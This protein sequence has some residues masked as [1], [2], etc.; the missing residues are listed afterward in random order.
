MLSDDFLWH[1]ATQC[2]IGGDIHIIKFS[3][4]IEAEVRK[5]DEALIRQL[6]DALAL[7][8]RLALIGGASTHDE[9][10]ALFVAASAG[11][12]RLEGKP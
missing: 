8:R 11:R 10:D 9:I 1:Q 5:Q 12:A 2:T 7:A 4:A 6:V 3:R